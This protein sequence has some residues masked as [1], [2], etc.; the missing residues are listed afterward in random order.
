[1]KKL[2]EW[3]LDKG[4]VNHT[5]T[6]PRKQPPMREGVVEGSLSPWVE[7]E[8]DRVCVD[9][10]YGRCSCEKGL[11]AAREIDDCVK[12]A[13]PYTIA[14]GPLMLWRGCPECGK[15]YNITE[16][17]VARYCSLDCHGKAN[18]LPAAKW[19]TIEFDLKEPGFFERNKG[20]C[21]EDLQ[22]VCSHKE[23]ESAGI[24]GDVECEGCGV[25]I[26]RGERYLY[27]QEHD[28]IPDTYAEIYKWTQE[29]LNA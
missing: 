22:A 27:L 21:K 7:G 24:R 17:P 12:D 5:A 29:H 13:L 28:T 16:S 23:W 18:G 14:T 8:P 11:E 20:M 19:E 6:S 2:P 9:C 25:Q 3:M 26:T 15:A 1:M 4:K 10:G